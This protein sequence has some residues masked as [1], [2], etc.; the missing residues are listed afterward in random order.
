M[1]DLVPDPITFCANAEGTSTRTHV[2]P[3][4]VLRVSVD[5]PLLPS[6][7]AN[8]VQTNSFAIRGEACIDMAVARLLCGL[9]DG[10]ATP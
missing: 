1:L 5:R 6:A 7:A 8:S 2:L 3:G 10:T 4:E 9:R